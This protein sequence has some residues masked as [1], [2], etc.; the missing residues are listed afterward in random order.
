MPF[1]LGANS[2]T[3]GYT[4]D[5]SLR[6]NSASSDYLS[7]T[8]ASSSNRKTWTVSLW[9][10]RSNLSTIQLFMGTSLTNSDTNT[11]EFGWFSDNLSV[12]RYNFYQFS[13]TQL[14]RDVSAWYHIVLAFDTTQATDSNRMKLY[15]NGSQVTSFSTVSY[16]TLNEDLPLISSGQLTNIGRQYYAGISS[17][18]RYLNGYLSEINFIDGQAL[19]PTDFGEFDEDSGIWKPIA[20]AG[21][22]GTN[23]FY[24][25][26]KDSGALGADTSGN[27]NNFTVNNLT[28]V[29]QMLDTPTNNFAT[30]NPIHKTGSLPAFS[31][32][33]LIVS[34][35]VANYQT[36][37]ATMGIST[38]LAY[39]EMLVIGT[40]NT[41]ENMGIG[42]D[43][44]QNNH[45]NAIN[46]LANTTGGYAYY[47]YFGYKITN[48]TNSAY[49]S[50]L[51]NGDILQIA[52]NMDTGKVWFGKN[53]V[54][55]A[56][57]NPSADTGEAFSG[58]VGTFIAGM[59]LYSGGYT[60]VIVNF[61]QDSSFAGNKT[62]Q[63]N[64]DSNNIGDFYYAPPT[65][66][67][68]LC[69]KNLAT[70]G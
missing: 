47:P 25:E 46:A 52:L 2:L 69:T 14:F 7:K 60:S 51:A 23:G 70:N 22:Y 37:F 16:P 48:S 20:Y 66:F 21:T 45:S 57:G 6:F 12:V 5:N 15:V 3:G 17:A 50:S 38:G 64:Q 39:M 63:S 55:P 10:K 11:M 67:L 32:G 18:D 41:G 4:V 59:T 65:G 28:A 30:F 56:S 61:G 36:S 33:N 54:Y 24:L 62:R 1:I 68:A 58:L 42:N 43:I 53:G 44:E 49:G 34:P 8:F 40:S 27:A 31:N 29:D 35:T 9:S 26:T 13:T 19:T